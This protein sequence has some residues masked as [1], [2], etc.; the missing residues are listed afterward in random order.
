MCNFLP[1]RNGGSM[2]ARILSFF[3]AS[4]FALLLSACSVNQEVT[5][6]D[7][8]A[9]DARPA[10]IVSEL[11]EQ[12]RQYWVAALAKQKM[13][14]NEG[15]INNFELS[16]RIIN[17][18]SYYPGIEQN[19]SYSDLSKS[20]IDDYRKF[21]DELPELPENMSFASLEEFMGKPV[22]EIAE[23]KEKPVKEE[24]IVK[25]EKVDL[26]NLEIPLDINSAVEN[27]IEYFSGRGKKF[28][29]NW[30]ARSGKY[31]PM[32]YR[33]FDEEGVPRQMAYLAMIESGLNPTARSWA[34]AVGMWQF[35]A[36]TGR[37]YGLNS[38]FYVD[39]RRNP[40][41]ATRAAA[42]HLKDLHRSLG[43][44]YL[45]LASYN[46]GEGRIT[47]AMKRAGSND[48][49]EILKYLPK[50][51]RNYVPGYIAISLIAMN[52]SEYGFDEIQLQE[53]IE[54]ET[55]KVYDAV[56]LNYF[57]SIASTSLETIQ[58]LN[59]DLLQGCTPANYSGGYDLKVPAGSSTL[60]AANLSN[61]PESAKKNFVFHYVG[62]RET[63][64]GIAS[65]YGVSTAELADANNVSTKSK[66]KRGTRLRIP[67][68]STYQPETDF[69]VNRGTT[70]SDNT[71]DEA[72]VAINPD[73]TVAVETETY[74]SNDVV[75]TE[76]TENSE[77]ETDADDDS[78]ETLAPAPE[79]KAAVIYTVKRNES[80]KSISEMFNVSVPE[81]RN[82]NNIAY[83]QTLKVGE[84]LTV[85]VPA[86]QQ[87]YYASLEAQSSSDKT[88]LRTSS[89]RSEDGQWKYHIV[90]RGE[91]LESIASLYDVSTE[92]IRSWNDISGNKIY[93]N[94]RLKIAVDPSSSNYASNTRT[95]R[96][97]SKKS[98]TYR[99]KRG[100]TLSGIAAKFDVSIASL[101]S[102]NRIKGNTVYKN[103]N[104]VINGTTNSASYGDDHAKTPAT[105]N[106]HRV[107]KGETI[108][109]IAAKFGVGV[110][111]IRKWNNIRGN[112]IV[113][114]K[115]LKVY[116]NTVVSDVKTSKSAV[117]KNTTKFHYVK[118]GESLGSIATKYG[119]TVA[120]LK[121]NNGLKSDKLSIKQKLVIK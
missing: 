8:S 61:I 69:A 28:V 15:V 47:R 52:P 4:L 80:L 23:G 12:S 112:K 53:P 43:H 65:R 88:N 57:A 22:H 49:W 17:N 94:A 117:K 66:L 77:V 38:N 118:R 59:P 50:E 121:K 115:V 110:N 70:G 68:K 60:I 1:H 109:S 63:L 45:A 13:H 10:K 21:L 25:R 102:W 2:K 56:D 42:R 14:D 74:A 111:D 27:Y 91:S 73:N 72:L 113:A 79:G 75:N 90:K 24:T 82:W 6:V 31:F 93:S 101:K 86:D 7:E 78:E 33:I 97:S 92:N 20:V 95:E 103:Q 18:L 108:G 30:L 105:A 35:M 51:T 26:S 37:M 9:A 100:E 85:Y 16:L 84:K 87:N 83:N 64:A 3:V 34:G 46:A 55:V 11:L 39:D 104:L 96:A 71:S 44:W 5:K 119:T 29:S 19:Q 120:K 41:K 67:F 89:E 116:S 114:G 106:Y 81:V 99:V 48:Y 40:E 107:R 32:I 54:Y 62:R 36:A 76:V 98:F 58:E